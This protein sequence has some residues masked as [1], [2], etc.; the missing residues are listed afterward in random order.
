[1]LSH[2]LKSFLFLLSNPIFTESIF[3]PIV[4]PVISKL[5]PQLFT[6]KF[7]VEFCG[8]VDYAIEFL[9]NSLNIQQRKLHRFTNI[10]IANNMSELRFNVSG[11]E[12]GIY[13]VTFVNQENN[14]IARKLLI[15]Y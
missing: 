10:D 15:G 5:N 13:Y 9:S 1:M 7:G 14:L 3:N 12:L 2:I 4:R 8:Y 11:Y 6:S